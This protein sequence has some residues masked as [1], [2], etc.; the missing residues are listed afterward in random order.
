MATEVYNLLN[1]NFPP[2]FRMQKSIIDDN[3]NLRCECSIELNFFSDMLGSDTFLAVIT[4]NY[5]V[6]TS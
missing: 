3:H 4:G 6:I 5:R 1:N 2:F